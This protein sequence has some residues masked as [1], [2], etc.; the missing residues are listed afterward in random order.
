MPIQIKSFT[1]SLAE[2]YAAPSSA[3]LSVFDGGRAFPG[4][5]F[6]GIVDLGGRPDGK[7]AEGAQE[8]LRKN[9]GSAGRAS[10]TGAMERSVAEAHRHVWRPGPESGRPAVVC[11]AINGGDLFVACR[12]RVT[13][14]AFMDG[15]IF[16]PE[17]SDDDDEAW[18]ERVD[19]ASDETLILG[20]ATLAETIPREA[21]SA[22]LVAEPDE[23][24]RRVYMMARE[25]PQVSALFFRARE[26]PNPDEP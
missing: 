22:I 18:M 9:I 21:E 24:A 5:S 20:N 19:L 13:A 17:F 25:Y 4:T 6:Y 3:F 2:G 12:G 8:V 16:R 10:L 14:L 1:L 15:Q 11:V 7:E 26:A 23:A